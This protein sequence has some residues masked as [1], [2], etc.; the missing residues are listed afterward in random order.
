MNV[1]TLPKEHGFPVRLVVPGKYG[2]KWVKWINHIEVI[3][4]DHKGFWESRGWDD[5]ADITPLS[6]WWPHASLLSIAAIFGGISAISGLKF[7][8]KSKFWSDLPVS[9]RFHNISS[10]IYYLI[11]FPVFF[12]WIF[13]TY[14]M[15]GDVFYT[16]H[17][18]VALAVIVLHTIGF[19]SGLSLLK[20]SK[21]LRM[22]HLFTNILGYFLLLGTM[23]SGIIISVST[24]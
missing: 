21:K 17:G 11:L 13:V 20:N 10:Y 15:R 14:D 6:E 23:I 5:D 8:N 16:N 9:R 7:S 1:E 19:I 2:Y 18:K 4:Y 22:T 24:V 12:Y 3:D